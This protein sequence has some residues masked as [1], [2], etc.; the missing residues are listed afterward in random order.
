[1]F[2]HCL[3]LGASG[4]VAT[5]LARRLSAEGGKLSIMGRH[6][7]DLTDT[8]AVRRTIL[9]QA[10]DVVINAAAYTLVDRAETEPDLALALNAV[11]PGAAAAAAS[12]VGA[13]FIHFSTDYVFDGAKGSPYVE[14][15]TPK[16]LGVYG[17]SKLAGER[18][19]AAA[20]VNH[21]IL[22]T[23]WVCSS[24]GS[25]F[26]KTM[27]RLAKDRDQVGVVNDQRGRPTF[28]ADLANATAEIISS[29]HGLN[30][31]GGAGVFHLGGADDATW[32]SFAIAIM[33]GS[34]VRGGD[35]AKVNPITTAE[36]PTPVR[37]PADSRLDCSRI[38]QVYGIQPKC[39]RDSLNRCL[40]EIY[41]V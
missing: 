27:L 37:R 41:A 10:P 21:I 11:G 5:A 6:Q 26:V 4:Q 19:V 25:N 20:N 17:V 13:S 16:P 2:R 22:R 15:D 31:T 14:G 23:A 8:A 40:D 3:I 38:S 12:E 35:W 1:M 30:T 34:R 7:L 9:E 28:A 29:P 18:A 33:Q 32:Y 24:T 39:W 36:F